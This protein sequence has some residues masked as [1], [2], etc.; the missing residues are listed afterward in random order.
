M[1][2]RECGLFPP[3]S[4]NVDHKSLLGMQVSAFEP[5]FNSGGWANLFRCQGQESGESSAPPPLSD[6]IAA[7]GAVLRDVFPVQTAV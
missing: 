5:K 1:R 2:R 3:T 6:L 4:T 7:W